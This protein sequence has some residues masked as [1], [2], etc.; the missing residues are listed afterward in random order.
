M[1]LVF[2]AQFL[3]YISLLMY[4]NVFILFAVRLLLPLKTSVSSKL[5][6]VN[7]VKRNLEL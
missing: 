1:F 5:C 2:G 7:Y 3:G 6:V 4:I